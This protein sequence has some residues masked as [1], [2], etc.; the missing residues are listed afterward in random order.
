ADAATALGTLIV[1]AAGNDGAS[2][3][4]VGT[5]GSAAGSERAVVVGAADLRGRTPAATVRIA[6]DGID[7]VFEQAPVLT[8]NRTAA[9]PSGELAIVVVEAGGEV[10]DY[11]DSELRSRVSGAV[12]LVA[13]RDDVTVARQVRAAADAG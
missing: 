6:G 7:Q 8:A 9:L 11:L 10:V 5:V 2:G 3:D 4:D 1:T 12:A 13:A